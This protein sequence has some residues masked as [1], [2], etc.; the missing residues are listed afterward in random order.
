MPVRQSTSLTVLVNEL[1]SNA[2]KH[3]RGAIRLALTTRDGRALLEVTDEGPGFPA[4]FDPV[5]AANTGLELIQTLA[6]LDLQGDTR[7]ENIQGGGAR[8]VVEFP[9]PGLTRTV[10]EQ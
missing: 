6:R 1:V 5:T 10:G 7:F 2:V 3:G 8:V 9:I 4:G